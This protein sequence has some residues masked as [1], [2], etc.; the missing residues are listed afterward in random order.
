MVIG[1]VMSAVLQMLPMARLL[2]GVRFSFASLPVV[3]VIVHHL[4]R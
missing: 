4:C 1:M 3:A 2:V